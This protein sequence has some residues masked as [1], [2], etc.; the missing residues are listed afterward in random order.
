[1]KWYFLFLLAILCLSNQRCSSDAT[2][3][4]YKEEVARTDS[5]IIVNVWRYEKVHVGFDTLRYER[6]K[7]ANTLEEHNPPKIR[8][9]K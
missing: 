4:L 8:F 2:K 7:S 3:V 9:N 5:T 1:M 6:R